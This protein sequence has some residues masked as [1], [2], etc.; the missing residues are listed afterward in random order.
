MKV[1]IVYIDVKPDCIEKF[2]EV[3]VYNHVNS[4]KEEGNIRFDVLQN[5]DDPTKFVL[6]EAWKDDAALDLHKTTEHY[7]KWNTEMLTHVTKPRSRDVYD[8][9]AFTN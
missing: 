5:K 4:V 3:T 6:Y 2:R 8:A 9:V 1:L 7:L